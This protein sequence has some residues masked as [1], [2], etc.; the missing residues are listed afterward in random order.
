MQCHPGHL[1]QVQIGE[2]SLLQW[3]ELIWQIWWTIQVEPC[4]FVELRIPFSINIIHGCV[5]LLFFKFVSYCFQDIANK[6]KQSWYYTPQCGSCLRVFRIM[7]GAVFGIGF[8]EPPGVDSLK[9]LPIAVEWS[10]K[11]QQGSCCFFWRGGGGLSKNDLGSKVQTQWK[12]ICQVY[13]FWKWF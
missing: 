8:Q 1:Y 12:V 11:H 6:N 10:K 4:E 2:A 13:D 9:S 7:E 3:L 5:F